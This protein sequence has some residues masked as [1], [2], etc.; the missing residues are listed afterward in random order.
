MRRLLLIPALVLTFALPGP[1]LAYATAARCDKN[2]DDMQW[3]MDK[4]FSVETLLNQG[5]SKDAIITQWALASK[6][7]P[8]LKVKV[9]R[10]VFLYDDYRNPPDVVG[11]L[12]AL[13]N[14]CL[15]EIAA[16]G[17]KDQRPR[18]RR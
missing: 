14:M 5:V 10:I 7:E 8:D 9:A 1:V 6:I 13:K 4:A 11:V 18:Q 15:D 2:G 17:I 16:D 3:I 12:A